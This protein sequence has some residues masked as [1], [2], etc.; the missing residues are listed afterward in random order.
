MYPILLSIPGVT[1]NTHL[2]V[3]RHV[4][5]VCGTVYVAES[6]RKHALNMS[7]HRSY[8]RK[9]LLYCGDILPEDKVIFIWLL[10]IKIM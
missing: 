3:F 10:L 7:A 9:T 6:L 4:T 1:E 5:F 2:R 8:E